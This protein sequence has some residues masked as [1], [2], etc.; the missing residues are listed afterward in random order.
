MSQPTSHPPHSTTV[1]LCNPWPTRHP[2]PIQ[3]K[4]D[5]DRQTAAIDHEAPL[6][7]ELVRLSRGDA[8]WILL[9]A[10]PGLPVAKQF[11]EWGINPARVLVLHSPKIK[12]WQRTLEQSLGNGHCAAVLTW[13]PEQVSLDRA[14]LHKL[15]QRSGVLTRFFEPKGVALP[16]HTG[17]VAYG[18][19]DI[20]LNH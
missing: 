17:T 13:L 16:P 8:G 3:S 2:G 12:N 11:Q 15:G 10:P 9:I 18:G 14:K 20:Y 6:L 5:Q 1:G 4:V 7:G 19:Q